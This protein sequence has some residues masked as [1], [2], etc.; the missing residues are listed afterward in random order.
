MKQ[1]HLV[2]CLFKLVSC[3]NENCHVTVQRRHL[4]EHV[5]IT[6]QLRILEC[7]HCTE[8]CPECKM[9]VTKYALICWKNDNCGSHS[10]WE[11]YVA[12]CIWLWSRDYSFPLS[13]TTNKIRLLILLVIRESI[14]AFC[15][16]FFSS[17]FAVTLLVWFAKI[18]SVY[19]GYIRYYY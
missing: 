5:A 1:V 18:K 16:E 8:P 7:D 15:Q 12:C 4:E 2:S 9:Q 17:S 19:W 3:T 6:F 10:W 11:G 14:F 13:V